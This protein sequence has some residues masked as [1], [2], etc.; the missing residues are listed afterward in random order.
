[1]KP[2]WGQDMK[3][4][5]L[6]LTIVLVMGL[7]V[8]CGPYKDYSGTYVKKNTNSTITVTLSA[9]G[10]FKWKC[11]LSKSNPNKDG[12]L[13]SDAYNLRT[14]TFSVNDSSIKIEFSYVDELGIRVSGH[15]TAVISDNK[16]RITGNEQI[17]GVYTKQ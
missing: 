14:G 10:D 9:S 2:I 15:A 3:K 1:M 4:F 12:P 11:V 13:D 16:L 7:C 5:A 8:G 17:A 6:L